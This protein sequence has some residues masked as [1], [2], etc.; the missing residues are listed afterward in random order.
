[1]MTGE[2]AGLVRREL[3]S[4]SLL[5]IIILLGWGFLAWAVVDMS[6]PLAQLMMPI[7][8]S[9][10]VANVLAVFLMWSVMMLAMMLPSATPMVLAFVKLSRSR[11]QNSRG[12]VFTAAY[13]AIWVGFSAG[14]T[15]LQ[16][17]F[18]SGGLT[19][20]MMTSS[21]VWLTGLL[22]LVAGIVQFTRL[23]EVCLHHCRTPMGFLLT[24]WEQGLSGAWRMGLKHGTYCLGCC[25][26][27]MGILFVTG[28]MN[29]AWV[30][31][32]SAALMVEKLHPLG[33]KLGKY[34]GGSLVLLG[35]MQIINLSAGRVRRARE[36]A[37]KVT[38]K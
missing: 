3:S 7:D 2:T 36:S 20:P 35:V 19:T 10:T 23:K 5:L 21:S 6:H 28:V 18:Q 14:A 38:Y 9:W 4:A 24:E 15:A 1:M 11:Q 12:L 34:L 30:A 25:W 27:I 17:A 32:L 8:A 13:L 37:Y 29:L 33:D 31:A 22:L 26:A 16:W